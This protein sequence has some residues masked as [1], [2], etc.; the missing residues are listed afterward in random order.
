[1]KPTTWY[2]MLAPD[3]SQ[4]LT[5][6]PPSG[7]TGT[8]GELTLVVPREPRGGI[9]WTWRPDAPDEPVALV[10]AACRADAEA[11]AA[12][13]HLVASLDTADHPVLAWHLHQG[14]HPWPD[15]VP[16]LASAVDPPGTSDTLPTSSGGSPSDSVSGEAFPDSTALASP[17]T[18][19]TSRPNETLAGA[20]PRTERANPGPDDPRPPARSIW[21]S[22]AHVDG[23]PPDTGELSVSLAGSDGP[24][25]TMLP[26]SSRS[27]RPAGDDAPVSPQKPG[28][29]PHP[30]TPGAGQPGV[31]E[32]SGVQGAWV[33]AIGRHRWT[34]WRHTPEGLQWARTSEGRFMTWPDLSTLMDH[35]G[36]ETPWQPVFW[37]PVAAS[38]GRRIAPRV[39]DHTLWYLGQW[40][41]E[42]FGLWH[43]TDQG[44]AVLSDARQR[45]VMTDQWSRALALGQR[46]GSVAVYTPS[47]VW[48]S[49]LRQEF[50]EQQETP[51]GVTTP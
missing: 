24:R 15:R 20:S 36:D 50:R 44:I 1:M 41:T 10:Y 38:H 29:G 4:A 39:E 42:R 2:W 13:Y 33:M 6:L 30:Q 27:R 48:L 46:T 35:A 3:R 31:G 22:A 34:L 11:W 37:T 16:A 8:G 7:D 49:F 51:R 23:K 43:P 32:P 5:V 45:L 21:Q 14:T 26:P 19:E 17:T 40:G 12:P 9:V 28:A 25:S 18:H 47:A